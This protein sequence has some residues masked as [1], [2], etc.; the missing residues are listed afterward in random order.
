MTL[1]ALFG[2][3]SQQLEEMWITWRCV[4]TG[5][6]LQALGLRGHSPSC[7]DTTSELCLRWGHVQARHK[8]GLHNSGMYVV[9]TLHC[10]LQMQLRDADNLSLVSDASKQPTLLAVAAKF[11]AKD[12]GT[13]RLI[14]NTV[15]RCGSKAA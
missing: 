4:L 9:L 8:A 13:V 12:R 6:L 10:C 15:L 1:L 7:L 14:D 11:P 2:S 3:A 5:I